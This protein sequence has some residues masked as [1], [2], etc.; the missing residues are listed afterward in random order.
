MKMLSQNYI[1]PCLSLWSP[2]KMHF[3]TPVLGEMLGV[4]LG[5]DAAGQGAGSAGKH[6]HNHRD[7]Q[8]QGNIFLTSFPRQSSGVGSLREDAVELI[9]VNSPSSSL[10]SPAAPPWAALR[11]ERAVA[12]PAS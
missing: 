5:A 10:S 11:R 7:T 9:A 8:A 12:P 6:T 2:Y 4:S 3:F 1:N